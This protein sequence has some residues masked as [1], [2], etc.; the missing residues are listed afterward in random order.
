[1]GLSP[2]LTGWADLLTEAKMSTQ[3]S[4]L[5]SPGAKFQQQRSSKARSKFHLKMILP[6]LGLCRPTTIV[7]F[8]AST[9]LA[10]LEMLSLASLHTWRA[11]NLSRASHLMVT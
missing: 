3:V 5:A 10:S 9:V 8:G 1:M 2:V 7:T 6:F 4:L 11:S